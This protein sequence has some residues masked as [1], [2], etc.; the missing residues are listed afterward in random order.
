MA[1][2]GLLGGI[3]TGIEKGVDSYFK[4]KGLLNDEDYRK[5]QIALQKRQADLAEEKSDADLLEKGYE[6]DPEYGK[7]P[8]SAPQITN[9]Q[10][11]ISE[12]QGLLQQSKVPIEK[13][14]AQQSGYDNSTG[15]L[16]KSDSD[17]L[18]TQPSPQPVQPLEKH[19][20]F[21]PTPEK[22]AQ[23][24][25]QKEELDPTSQVSKNYQSI[26]ASALQQYPQYKELINNIP[27]LSAADLKD[28]NSILGKIIS[29]ELGAKGQQ[30]KGQGIANAMAGRVGVMQDNQTANASN[31][32]DK[33]PLIERSTAQLAQLGVDRHTLETSPVVT[34]QILHEISNGI[35]SA[36]NGGR[37]AGLGMSQMQDL[38]TVQTDFAKLVQR[39]T[40]SP[41]EG[42][43]PAI[44]KQAIDTISR[45]EQAYQNYQGNLANKIAQGRTYVHNA[46]A[47]KAVKDAAAKY[48]PGQGL[49]TGDSQREFTSDV[50]S[51][52]QK[53]GIT[54]DQ[55]LAIKQ[56][57]TGKQ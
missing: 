33:H 3:G 13:L 15:L 56:K 38:S 53:H 18:N 36:M 50:V 14:S 47:T 22:M 2:L 32:I 25:R 28:Q 1:D 16:S 46:D 6:K 52:A 26:A 37:G 7:Q 17:Q 34:P 55:A 23:L 57:R 44:K 49:L 54:N 27:T 35:A 20:R 4:A 10:P 41:Q 11:N 48:Q 12:G 5:Q 40:N 42:A 29:G 24:K 45:L 43:S 8:L 30:I 31:I 39:L 51:Y 19:G 21:R 9:P